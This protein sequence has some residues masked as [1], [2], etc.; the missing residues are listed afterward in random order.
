[1]KDDV[2]DRVLL[3]YFLSYH[4]FIHLLCRVAV[5]CEKF[6]ETLVKLSVLIAYEG[7]PLH[8]ALFPKLWTEIYQSQ[9]SMAKNCVKLLCD[10]PV[11][12]EYIK[13]I[14][15][16]ERICLNSNAVY[17]FLACYLPKVQNQVFSSSNCSSLINNLIS[18]LI[19][20]YHNLEPELLGQRV[21]I[22]KVGAILNGDLRALALLLSIHTPKLLDAALIQTLQDLLHKCRTCQQQRSALQEQEAKE[23]KT[24]DDEGATPVKRRRVSSDE[25]HPLDNS[26][27]HSTP[28]DTR[29]EPREALTPA[30]TSDTETR[31]SAVI[32]PGTEHDPPTPDPISVKEDKM[33]LS[34]SAHET[35]ISNRPQDSLEQL[36]G[37]D[38]VED[39][40][41]VKELLSSEKEA[42]VN[43]DDSDSPSTPPP[44]ATVL[45]DLTDLRN[46]E[47]QNLPFDPETSLS[48]S[49]THSRGLFNMQQQDL[50]DNLCR[51]IESTISA[52][53]RILSRGNQPTS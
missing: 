16:D 10:E 29:T 51:T 17:T 53:T 39:C 34:S 30:S 8:L 5:N 7:L 21:E 4:Q 2:Y 43:E 48:N 49:C 41:G 33:E 24:K 11:F 6:T 52:V 40:K 35:L 23:R 18:N 44:V 19:N 9:S 45:S 12:A 42:S 14:L 36:Q 31:D 38:S 22:S 47:I 13:C 26:T 1:G 46:C 15:M 32:D 50:L 28:S 3:D 27:G 37:E 25:E 20:E